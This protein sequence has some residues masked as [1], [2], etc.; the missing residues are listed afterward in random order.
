MCHSIFVK[1][2]RINTT[3]TDP[4]YALWTP[5]ASEVSEEVYGLSALQCSGA[6]CDNERGLGQGTWNSLTLRSVF[7]FSEMS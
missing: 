5:G 7:L 4:E 6:G 1:T 3:K 2:H